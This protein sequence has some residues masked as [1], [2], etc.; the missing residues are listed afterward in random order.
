LIDFILRRDNLKCKQEELILKFDIDANVITKTRQHYQNMAFE[1]ISPKSSVKD[2]NSPYNS[3]IFLVYK[4]RESD[5]ESNSALKNQ[6]QEVRN[7]IEDVFK[8]KELVIGAKSI[9]KF[10]DVLISSDLD[11]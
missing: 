1:I 7:E 2:S 11:G 6:L 8:T 9:I 4:F 5:E 3:H 10:K